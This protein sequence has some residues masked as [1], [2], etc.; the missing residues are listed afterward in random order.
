MRPIVHDTI[1]DL[2]PQE[3]PSVRMIEEEVVE[4]EDEVVLQE[5]ESTGFKIPLWAV[6]AVVLGFVLIIALIGRSF[7]KG[8]EG[9]PQKAVSRFMDAVVAR[10]VDAT[11]SSLSASSQQMAG[12]APL[13]LGTAGAALVQGAELTYTIDREEKL[14]SDITIVWCKVKAEKVVYGSDG[15]TF[16]DLIPIFAK[17]E[18]GKWIADLKMTAMRQASHKMK[19]GPVMVTP[20]QVD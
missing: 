6:M 8:P 20:P 18:K 12:M 16:E 2:T 17:V 1:D 4:D 19:K 10:D 14:D 11:R 3:T 7:A 5:P 9:S 15:G 13:M